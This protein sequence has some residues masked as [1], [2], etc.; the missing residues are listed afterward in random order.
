MDK[1]FFYAI[2]TAVNFGDVM[3]LPGKLIFIKEAILTDIRNGV[4]KAAQFTAASGVCRFR[5]PKFK[6]ISGRTGACGRE[7][8]FGRLALPCNIYGVFAVV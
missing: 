5:Q 3:K 7:A 8:A 6:R 2:L 1:K 4:L